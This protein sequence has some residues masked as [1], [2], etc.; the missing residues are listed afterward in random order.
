MKKTFLI[1]FLMLIITS[2]QGYPCNKIAPVKMIG[3]IGLINNPADYIPGKAF[4][5]VRKDIIE[6]IE[7][8][9]EQ[10][11]K[12]MRKNYSSP[13]IINSCQNGY[14]EKIRE[15]SIIE[16]LSNQELIKNPI[17]KK[18]FPNCINNLNDLFLTSL[19]YHHDEICSLGTELFYE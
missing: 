10:I 16:K 9:I 14:Q 11:Q 17:T 3:Y 8:D 6:K 18:Y 5:V 19:E 2:L 7:K 4:D 1:N 12:H 13:G 15:K